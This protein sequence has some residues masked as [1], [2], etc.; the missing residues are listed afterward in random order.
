[1]L[2]ALQLARTIFSVEEKRRILD[3]VLRSLARLIYRETR[4]NLTRST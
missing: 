1:M 3:L 4:S 2:G